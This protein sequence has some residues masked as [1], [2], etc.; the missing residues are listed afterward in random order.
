VATVQTRSSN[1]GPDFSAPAIAPRQFLMVSSPSEKKVVWTT[2]QNFESSDGRTFALID[3]GLDEPKGLAF[4]HKRGHLY[5]ADSGA[6]KIFRYTIIVDLSG[7]TPNLSTTGVRLTITQG[8]AVE[9]VTCDD[10]GNLFYTAPDTNNINKIPAEVMR[11]VANG[12]FP[13]S[14]LQIV[15]E[16][17]T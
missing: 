16:K 6:K 13:P 14:V 3:S 8:H 5:I 9:W 15:S 2:L 17:K 4:D 10:D 7:D 11:G 12:E 1:A